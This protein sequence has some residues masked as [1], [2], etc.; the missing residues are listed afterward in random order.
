MKYYDVRKLL[1]LETYTSGGGLCATLLQVRDDLSCRQDEVLNNTMLQA[2]GFASKSL[3]SAEWQHNNIEKH[4]G[5]CMGWKSSTTTALHVKY[6][7]PQII[8]HWWL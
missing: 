1:C 5:S 2:I 4:A 7:S 3:C 6:M 8:N